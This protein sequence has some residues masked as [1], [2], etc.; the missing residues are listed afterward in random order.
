[1]A[2]LK[3]TPYIPKLDNYTDVT[4]TVCEKI[5]FIEFQDTSSSS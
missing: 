1:M 4:Y 3:Y 2:T 5:M